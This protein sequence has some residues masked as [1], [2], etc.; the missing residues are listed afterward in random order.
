[1]KYGS[2]P[3][4][5]RRYLTHGI[6]NFA[7][8]GLLG[9]PCLVVAHHDVFRDHG[10]KLTEFMTR[11]NRLNWSLSWRSLGDVIRR[12]F[13]THPLANGAALVRIFA[14]HLTIE[15][16]SAEPFEAVM[17]KQEAD[18]DR[19]EAV[20]VNETPVGFGFEQEQMQ[21]KVSIPPREVSEIRITYDPAKTPELWDDGMTNKAK[22]SL[23]RY[24]SEFRDN[25]LSRSDL[26]HSGAARARNFL[27]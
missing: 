19:V 14:N 22:I 15:N 6:E 17:V 3:I 26:L 8:D 10:R 20:V 24:L 13:R 7:F 5:T 1:M 25:Y 18:P 2:F 27:R 4:F 11:L 12:S 16:S 23:R 21:F 9:K